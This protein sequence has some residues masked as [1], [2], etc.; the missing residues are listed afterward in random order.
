MTAG[1]INKPHA[2]LKAAGNNKEQKIK[3]ELMA[4]HSAIIIF[5]GL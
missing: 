2:L 4:I 3:E 1:H 5:E